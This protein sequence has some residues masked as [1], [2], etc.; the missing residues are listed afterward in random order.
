[1][2]VPKDRPILPAGHAA[3]IE[4][5]MPV[6]YRALSR[7]MPGVGTVYAIECDGLVKIGF[8][9]G[10]VKRRCAALQ[11]AH[12][13]E[14]RIVGEIIGTPGMEKTL[15]K[16]FAKFRVRGEW[17]RADVKPFFA[18]VRAMQVTA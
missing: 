12:A 7:D 13:S 15:H 17:F 4:N 5:E 6:S 11:T 9:I 10:D 16:A 18:K 1:M 8:T 14:L 3:R 2:T